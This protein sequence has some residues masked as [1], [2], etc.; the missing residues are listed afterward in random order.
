[1]IIMIKLQQHLFNVFNT[2]LYITYLFSWK[3]PLYLEVKWTASTL[4]LICYLHM[5]PIKVK[6]E[7]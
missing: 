1:M 7:R 4:S 2:V 6:Y 3:V 5:R